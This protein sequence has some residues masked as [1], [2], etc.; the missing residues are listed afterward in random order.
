LLRRRRTAREAADVRD[1]AT[2]RQW[3]RNRSRGVAV[4]TAMG[5][6][7]GGRA[8]SSRMAAVVGGG[9]G[10]SGGGCGGDNELSKPLAPWFDSRSH[11]LGVVCPQPGPQSN[12][13]I[14][15][16]V[17]TGNRMP[18]VRALSGRLSG[19]GLYRGSRWAGAVLWIPQPMAARSERCRR[20]GCQVPHTAVGAGSA[21]G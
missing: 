20:D 17:I 15:P 16:G 5:S 1:A 8:S 11:C 12:H 21:W 9:G 18:Q 3:R 19:G 14:S 2:E 6:K 10:G 13:A 4:A 7:E